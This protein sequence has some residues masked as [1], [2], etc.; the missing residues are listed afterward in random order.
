MKK[1]IF[2][3]AI[4]IQTAFAFASNDSKILAQARQ[5]NVK[6]YLQPGTAAPIVKALSTQDRIEVVRKFNAQWTIVVV[7]GQV[8]YVL[9]SEL[10]K[11]QP[12][13]TLA[14]AKTNRKTE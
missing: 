14:V 9:H 10:G 4:L 1:L 11:P 6:M 5:D 2:T 3:F 13:K 12:F 8:G 7:D